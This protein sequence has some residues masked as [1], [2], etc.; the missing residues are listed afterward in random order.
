MNDA[1]ETP[2]QPPP[3]DAGPPQAPEAPAPAAHA[4]GTFEDAS[5]Q[6]LSEA[7]HSSFRVIKVFMIGLTLLFLCSGMFIVEPNEVVVKLLFGKPEGTGKDQLLQPGWHWAWP[8][9]INEKVRIKVGQSHTVSSTTGWYQVTP[10]MAAANAQPQALG[11]LRPEADGYTLTA[12]GNI[13][14]VRATIKYRITDPIQYAFGFTNVTEV[15]TNIVNNAIF[16]ASARFTADQALYKEKTAFRD[17]VIARVQEKIEA[18][19]VGIALEPSDVE[20]VAAADVRDAFEK[21]NQMEQARSSEI[22]RARSYQEELVNTALGQSN[23]IVN[24]GLVSSN[25]I[26]SGVQAAALAFDDQLPQYVENP[27]LFQERLLAARLQRVL[28]NTNAKF[29]L[30]EEFSELRLQLSREP[31]SR[32][33]TPIP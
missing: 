30:P 23:A 1:P 24:A 5:S 8:Y 13:I 21:V 15:L 22:S 33:S 9:P 3:A 31:E 12:D 11:Y 14:H 32:E 27:R 6:A 4:P 20:T 17:A 29:L 7:L 28:T 26:V 2:P 25:R 19:E 16:H 18:H 10:E